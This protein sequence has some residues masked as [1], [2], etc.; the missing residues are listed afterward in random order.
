VLVR[1]LSVVRLVRAG[2]VALGLGAAMSAGAQQIAF[3]FDDLPAHGPL[4]P[5]ETRIQVRTR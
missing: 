2:V 4:P 5:G 1:R 3:T